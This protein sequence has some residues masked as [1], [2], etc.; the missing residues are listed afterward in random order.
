MYQAYPYL[1]QWPNWFEQRLATIEKRLNDL[2]IENAALK[3][4]LESMQ[5][6]QPSNVTYKIQELHVNE[7]TGTLNIGFTAH[8]DQEQFHS[9]VDQFVK[10]QGSPLENITFSQQVPESNQEDQETQ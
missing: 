3:K 8:A 10:G 4:Q 7:L 2:E 9:M 6:S 1:G 5:A